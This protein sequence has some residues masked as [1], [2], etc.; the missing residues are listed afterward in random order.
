MSEFYIKKKISLDFLGEEYKEA[1]LMF[2]S[3]PVKL[4]DKIFKDAKNKN[5]LEAAKA[6]MI[7]LKERFIEGQFP[8]EDGKLIGVKVE[9]LDDI[10]D[11]TT[12][13]NCYLTLIGQSPDPKS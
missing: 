4:Y 8:D 10:V 6:A 9:D 5:N 3:I 11:E 2:K 1:Y 12:L 13:N 7:I